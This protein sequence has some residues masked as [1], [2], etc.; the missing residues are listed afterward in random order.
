MNY[1]SE[2]APDYNHWCA[3]FVAIMEII[4]IFVA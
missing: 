2:N 1:G 4:P 3:V